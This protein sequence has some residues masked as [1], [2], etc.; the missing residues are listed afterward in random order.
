MNR[1]AIRTQPICGVLV[2]I[3][4]NPALNILAQNAG[5]DFVFYDCEH[6][7]I[8]YEKLHDLILAGNSQGIESW[9][10]VPQ[11]ARSDISRALDCGAKGVMVPMIETVEQAELLVA[12]SKY[13]PLG[14]RSYSGG[15]NTH[16]APSGNH[17]VNMNQLNSDT[18]TIVQIET[19]RGVANVDAILALTGV[20]GAIVG[21]ADLGIS[22][23]LDDDIENP[24]ELEAIAQVAAACQKHQKAFGI[25]GSMDMC[26][27][28]AKD[29]NIV[30]SAIDT[31]ILRD[32]MK[33]WTQRFQDRIYKEK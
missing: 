12:Y 8:S 10:R 32:G 30:V 16:Y 7:M 5:M 4:A 27:H 23:G 19:K 28:F 22:L 26:A 20:D 2:K 14:G 25:I 33:Q 9:I 24:R 29:I 18:M 21:P 15:A 1:Q 17:R 31:N 11:L 6:G 3:V 13:P